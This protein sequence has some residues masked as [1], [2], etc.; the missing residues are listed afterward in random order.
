MKKLLALL[1]AMMLMFTFFVV[2]EAED[3]AYTRTSDWKVEIG[4]EHGGMWAVE[5]AF[6]GKNDT[7]WH[8]WYKAEGSTIVEKDQCP[9]TMTVTFPEPLEISMVSYTPRQDTNATGTWTKAEIYGSTDGVNFT[10]LVDETYDVVNGRKEAKTE[11]PRNSY[12]SIRFVTTESLSGFST[13]AELR[14]YKDA[15]VESAPAET[16]MTKVT[17]EN[18]WIVEASSVYVHNSIAKAFDGNPAT[19]WHSNYT[20][21]DGVVASHDEC[22][23][24]VIV[25]FT[26]PTEYSM[27][28]YLPRKDNGAGIWNK[29]E[30]YG[31]ADGTNFTKLVDAKYNVSGSKEMATTEI[32]QAKYKAIKIVVTDGVVGYATAAEINF[33]NVVKEVKKAENGK[34]ILETLK[35]DSFTGVT[36]TEDGVTTM[37]AGDYFEIERVDLTG[38]KSVSF[39]G[40]S[41]IPGVENGD[42]YQIRIDD[43]DKGD[44]L[45]YVLFNKKELLNATFSANIRETEGVHDIYIKSTYGQF[46]ENVIRKIIFSSETVDEG[47]TTVVPDSAIV[48]NYADTWVATDALGRKLADYEEAGPVKEGLHEV[49]MFYW[50]WAP[51]NTNNAR[52]PSEI[53]AKYP[54]AKDDYYHEAWD[55][56]GRYFWGEPLFGYYTSY[57]YF[58]Y[59]R[60]AEMLANAGVDSIFL[61]MSN[62][63]WAFVPTS[64]LIFEAFADAKEA[65]V[66]IPEI[67][68]WSTNTD[69]G[70]RALYHNILSNPRFRDIW[71]EWDG[72]LLMFGGNPKGA[73]EKALKEADTETIRVLKDILDISTHRGNGARNIGEEAYG[74]NWQWLQNYPQT[75]WKT[76]ADAERTEAMTLGTGINHSYVFEYEKTGVFSDPYVKGRS[77]TEAF[78]EDYRPDA[79]N[80]GYFFKEQ[81]SRVFEEDPM[82]VIIDG[83]NEWTAGRNAEYSGFTNAFV[84]TYDEENSRDFEP[85]RGA[86]RDDYYMLLVDFCRKYKGVRPAPLATAETVID[87]AAGDEQWASVGPEF[88]NVVEGYERD[89]EGSINPETGE[90]FHYTT[91]IS[92]LIKSAKVARD[93]EKLYFTAVCEK[94]I[95]KND[96]FMHLYIDAD[97]NRATGWEGYDYSYNVLGIGT[98][99]KYENG[100][101]V[102]LTGTE[103]AIKGKRITVSVPRALIGETGKVDLEFKWADNVFENGDLLLFYEHGSVAPNGRFNYLYTEIEQKSLDT[104][105]RD[106][107]YETTVLK[108]NHNRMNVNGG[109]MYVYE[110]DTRITTV[111]ENGMLYIPVIAAEEILGYGETKYEF[112]PEKNMLHLSSHGLENFEITDYVWSYTVLGTNEVRINGRAAAL[113]NPVKVI[114]GICYIP[115]SYFSDV[116]GWEVKGENGIWTVAHYG[117]YASAV[118]K[119]AELL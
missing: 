119:A 114:N 13:I 36:K 113:T 91:K 86:L 40:D 97:R 38:M 22:P 99:A 84:D 62:A 63:T 85:S 68:T 115:L 24:T 104:T 74:I 90:H 112:Y 42:A 4:S 55:T 71:Y 53:V 70:F 117:A 18:G 8:S 6:D 29:A 21:K 26:E 16:K 1:M 10:K 48:D 35:A 31:S 2:A 108:E 106:N 15:P 5:L 23:H 49:S 73:Y 39:L 17:L 30:I 33:L 76:S 59:R 50:N 87:L 19:Y 60:H 83:W 101:W 14:F 82:I 43:P 61:D 64:V 96:S 93:A 47:N 80:Q 41:L 88:L 109:E 81:A 57:D 28:T 116:F 34:I 111:V 94:D 20:V 3:G 110:P 56:K 32:P 37:D 79:K 11:I 102:A 45:G 77:Y 100:A 46:S 103:E 44:C 92:N 54:E 98:F 107:L 78:G 95:V 75:K 67:Y 27:I 9:H 66:N 89:H 105:T 118:A 51:N 25:T 72:K 69:K 52:I 58:A 7:Y 12:K 65:G